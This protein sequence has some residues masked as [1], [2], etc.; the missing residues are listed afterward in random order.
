MKKIL[1]FSVL[2][3]SLSLANTN[4]YT[5]K[6]VSLYLNKDDTKVQGRLLPTN[7]FQVVRQEACTQIIVEFVIQFIKK[8]NLQQINGQRSFALWLIEPA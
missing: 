2:M 3:L 6:V 8:M 4:K 7:P 5:D 1:L